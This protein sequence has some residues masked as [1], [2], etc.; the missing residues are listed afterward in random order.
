MDTEKSGAAAQPALEQET[1]KE[2][3]LSVEQ[4]EDRVNPAAPI[5]A[6]P[7]GTGGGG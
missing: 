4:V 5:G 1:P 2:E 6:D 7:T 3:Q